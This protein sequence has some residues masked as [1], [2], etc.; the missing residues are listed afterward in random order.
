MKQN[1]KLALVL[2]A[3][4]ALGGAG[5]T[6]IHA[7]QPKPAPGYVVAEVEVNDNDTF[8]KYASQVPGTLAPFGG[9]YVIRA[10]KVTPLP[11]EGDPPKGRFIVIG[12]DSVEK[13]KAWEDSPA[14]EAIK[15][16]RHASAKSRV[17]IIEGPPAQ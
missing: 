7:Q 9:K 11:G 2:L 16:L 13:A 10:G 12:F 15:P 8:Q 6:A 17:F 1:L 14:Y 4:V 3:G 5:A